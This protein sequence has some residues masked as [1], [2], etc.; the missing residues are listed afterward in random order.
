MACQFGGTR[1]GFQPAGAM[2][3]L[4]VS[5]AV[6]VNVPGAA[7]AQ[8]S[9]FNYVVGR[10]IADITGPALG[11]QMWGYARPGQLTEGIHLRQWA[12]AFIIAQPGGPAVA[13][14]SADLGSVTHE[15]QRAVVERLA[16]RYGDRYT[17]SNIVISATH[18]HSGPGGY[19]HY[20]A[21][22]PLGGPFYG[23]YFEAIVAGITSAVVAAHEDLQP[24]EILINRGVV[25]NAGA[26][27]SLPA[28]LNNPAD[29][30]ARYQGETDRE[31]T[32]LKLVDATG[33][34]GT[35][36][37]FAVHP[38]AMTYNN[39][40]ISGDHKGYASYLFER[41]KGAGPARPGD[42]VAAFAQ[43]NAGDVTANLNLDNTGP[44]ENEFET[45][46]IIAQRQLDKALELFDTAT[47]RL[48]GPIDHRHTY[49]DFSRLTVRGEFTGA[50]PQTTCPSAYGYSFAAG[51]TE[52]GG[53]HPLFREGMTERVESIDALARQ[54]FPIPPPSDALR[55]CHRPKAILFAP[56]AVEPHPL[57]PQIQPLGLVRIGQL[58]LVVGP[59]EFT[60]MA[61]RRIRET[62]ADVL[63]DSARYVVIA[64]YANGYAGYVTTK[65]EYD[66]Q[67]YEGGH[68]LYGPW[69]HAGYGQE[70]ARL[71]QALAAGRTVDSGP[72]PRD[73][74]GEIPSTALGTE[75]DT[76]PPG[77]QFGDVIQQ[78][79]GPYRSGETARAVFWTGNPRNGYT[80]GNNY[81]AV[82]R[83]EGARWSNVASDA[84]WETKCRWTKSPDEAHGGALQVIITWD[85]PP[86][87]KPG[88]YRIVH[89]G[90]YKPKNQGEPRRFEA[91]SEAFS[92]Q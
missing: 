61:G 37:W 59:A 83:R 84:N 90:T 79:E 42:F 31:M 28:Y 14:V 87:A 19:W 64:G 67:Q 72:T 81:L 68:T 76:V 6:A 26:Q 85:I 60:T 71:A 62:V 29:E 27:R 7:H 33:A 11:I 86:E 69:T 39:R 89:Y 53:G 3:L 52:D 70:F 78:P 57:Q 22:S 56:G 54:V 58:A 25:E 8:R 66:T 47:E 16:E 32:L 5:F 55:A 9:H 17:R 12:R 74:R 13:L 75:P 2:L 80:T 48:E 41:M 73:V 65:E 92:V 34:I 77:H 23:D 24:G 10:G 51:S 45:T 20:G 38:T 43:T 88:T 50:G 91:A 36:N 82:Q 49:V 15:L 21:G 46:R 44:G 4:T 35:I 30:R 63:G 18:T 1:W 40:L